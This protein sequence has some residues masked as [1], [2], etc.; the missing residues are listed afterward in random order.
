MSEA[1]AVPAPRP[2]NRPM[3]PG[4]IALA[5][6]V[7]ALWGANN[8]AIKVAVGAIP[9]LAA[10]GIRFSLGVVF[11]ALWARHKGV[12]LWPQPGELRRLAVLAALFFIQIAA[13]NIGQKLT[14]AVRGT[15]F[16]AAHPLFVGLFASWW[17]PGDRLTRGKLL[18]LLL[19]FAGVLVTFAEGFLA[20]G[21]G[22]LGDAVVLAS[23]IL[24]GARLV[25]LKLVVQE[26]P[27]P[28]TLFW[29]AG[30]SLPVFFGLS[31]WLERGSWGVVGMPHVVAMGYQGV[32]VAG[33]CFATNAWLYEHFRASQIAGY[34]FTVPLWGV[35]ICALVAHDPLTLSLVAGVAMVAL[36]IALASRDAGPDDTT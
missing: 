3:T 28:R 32:V 10:A 15:V 2:L 30:L 22:L 6:L 8:L 19:A 12:G 33:F 16:L 7:F 21:A 35:A 24:L 36:G 29:Q 14:S 20:P 31:A 4:A 17:V 26:V 13:L 11:F 25:L 23:A 5:L 1:T 9:P 34:T 18:G 27:P